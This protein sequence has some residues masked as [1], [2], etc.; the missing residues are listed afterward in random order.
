MAQP[1]E[2]Q[3]IASTPQQEV[4]TLWVVARLIVLRHPILQGTLLAL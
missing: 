2:A 1:N 3:Q 4:N